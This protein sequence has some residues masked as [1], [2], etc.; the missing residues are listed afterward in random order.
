VSAANGDKMWELC[1]D[2]REHLIDWT[3]TNHPQ[4]L[5]RVR[6]SIVEPP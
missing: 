6:A 1:C 3:R 2:V 5:P 4:A